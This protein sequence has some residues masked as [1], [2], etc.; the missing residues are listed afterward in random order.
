MEERGR[1]LWRTRRRPCR[2]FAER[3]EKKRER[4]EKCSVSNPWNEYRLV[5]VHFTVRSTRHFVPVRFSEHEEGGGWGWF[6]RRLLSTK[7]ATRYD[8][9]VEGERKGEREIRLYFMV[10]CAREYGYGS[11][12]FEGFSF[13]L[14]KVFRLFH[15]RFSMYS[16][17]ILYNLMLFAFENTFR[18]K[19]L[20]LSFKRRLNFFQQ[21]VGNLFFI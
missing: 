5:F 17:Y 7:T 3:E 11:W 18:L 19:I 8:E 9:F 20:K 13:S 14:C 1:R 12:Y 21:L 4:S 15:F 10:I 6:R 16:S 2:L